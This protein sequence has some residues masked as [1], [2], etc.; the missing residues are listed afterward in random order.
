[1]HTRSV[2]DHGHRTLRVW[3]VIAAT[4]CTNATTIAYASKMV[5]F[6]GVNGVQTGLGHARS[7]T[8]YVQYRIAVPGRRYVETLPQLSLPEL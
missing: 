7:W 1:M 6:L 3:I 5:H 2:T 8:D 4:E